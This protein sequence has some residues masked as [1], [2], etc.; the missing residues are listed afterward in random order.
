M[1]K[2]QCMS[3]TARV[4]SA[5]KI[6]H[7]LLGSPSTGIVYAVFQRTFYLKKT[8]NLK[9]EL[10]NSDSAMQAPCKSTTSVSVSSPSLCCIGQEELERGPLNISTTLSHTPQLEIGSHWFS[11]QKLVTIG[12]VELDLACATIWLPSPAHHVTMPATDSVELLIRF[13]ADNAPR[14][15]KQSRIK[16]MIDEQLSHASKQLLEWL[17]NS[18]DKR[19]EILFPDN[20]LGCGDGLTPAGDDIV[21]GVLLASH[22]W[23]SPGLKKLI[24]EVKKR[25]SDTNDISAAHLLAACSGSGIAPLHHLIDCIST[26][27]GQHGN[28]SHRYEN[29]YE[30][31]QILEAANTLCNYGHS[32]GYYAMKGVLMAAQCQLFRPH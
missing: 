17:D 22:T 8:G 16:Q 3:N 1:P 13:V 26:R 27:P 19:A 5:G 20:L 31:G 12:T 10:A 25:T 2:S 21:V 4:T 9:T 32:S 30:H 23:N 24:T 29:D 15:Q 11:D 6:A 7:D 14:P 18:R 28:N